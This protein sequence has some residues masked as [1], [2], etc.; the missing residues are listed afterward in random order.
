M[1]VLETTTTIVSLEALNDGDGIEGA[2]EFRFTV[3][4]PGENKSWERTISTGNRASLNWTTSHKSVYGGTPLTSYVKITCSE[5]DKDITG[6]EYNDGDMD[7]RNARADESV[8]APDITNYITL[9]NNECKVRLHYTIKS[10]V[11]EV[12]I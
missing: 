1:Q 12:E 10:K 5:I 9:G 6:R 11:T 8:P 4:V 2:G 7:Y 3:E